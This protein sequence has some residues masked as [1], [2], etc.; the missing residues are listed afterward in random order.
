[1][2][3]CQEKPKK[4]ERNIQYVSGADEVTYL[5]IGKEITDTV[6]KT[7][8]GNLVKAMKE[9]GAVAAVGFCNAKAMELT[10][11]YSGKY[12]T[13]VKRVSDKNRNGKNAPNTIESE[14][15]LDFKKLLK[16]GESLSPRVAIDMEGRK[17]FYAPILT[18]APCLTCHG[19]A[20]ALQPELVELIDSLYPQDK[21]K[22]YG[23]GELRGIWS[24][25]FKKS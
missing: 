1:M 7:L 5:K 15:I 2:Q 11:V 10:S 16:D 23:I 12:H 17:N 6:G 3:S 9:H 21:A 20:D 24:I 14:V 4:I 18:G 22:G 19:K 25:K 8:K 13:E